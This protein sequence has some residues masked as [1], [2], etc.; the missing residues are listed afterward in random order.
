MVVGSGGREHTLGWKLSKSPLV[1]ELVFVPGNG[2][3]SE[4]GECVKADIGDAAALADIAG[5]RNKEGNVFG[6]MPH[7]E[8]AAEKILGSE[9]G[10]LIFESVLNTLGISKAA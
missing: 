6:M 1:S 7:P 9:D 5:I 3:M 8:R 2:G 4:L 10:R